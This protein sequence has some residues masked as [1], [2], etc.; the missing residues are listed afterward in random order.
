EGVPIGDGLPASRFGFPESARSLIDISQDAMVFPQVPTSG[1]GN[2]ATAVKVRD[3]FLD[4]RDAGLTRLF[5]L[6]KSGGVNPWNIHSHI[7]FCQQLMAPSQAQT[8]PALLVVGEIGP[9]LLEEGHCL[10]LFLFALLN[11]A[12]PRHDPPQRLVAPSNTHEAP[13]RVRG[14]CD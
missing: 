8:I 6:I 4:N 2:V 7:Q 11:P 3:H 1:Y 10:E 14:V 12:A 9:E 5:R 13:R